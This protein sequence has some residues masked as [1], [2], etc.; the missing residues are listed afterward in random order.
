MSRICVL[1]CTF[2]R[3]EMLARLLAA[4]LP[5]AT[6]CGATV[7]IADN[8]TVSAQAVV[9]RFRGQMD[10]IYT[11]LPEPG[12]VNARNTTLRLALPLHPDYLVFIDDDE[13]PEG[14]WLDTLVQTLE[15]SGGDFATGPVLPHFS[16]PPPAWV[17]GS[18]FFDVDADCLGTSNLAIRTASLPGDEREW[19][20]PLFN[21][22]GGE[23]PELLRR[24]LAKGALHVIAEG[25][26]VHENVP[27]ER[28]RRRYIWRRG[29]R[30]GVVTAMILRLR[31]PVRMSFLLHLSGAMLGKTG[32]ALNHMF[33]SW[34]EPWRVIAAIADLA[35]VAGLVAAALG[36]RP[37]FYG[38][39]SKTR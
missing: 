22:T 21:F 35:A 13:L 9:D 16:E 3:H 37:T 5:Q 7:V 27:P 25:A 33:W 29:L 28:L 30:D 17:A 2:D 19:F 31:H 6:A 26:V 39:K 36:L 1:I 38:W 12:L 10:I 23:D 11:R 24:M 32:Y 4:L 18:R 8:G 14:D 20:N 15:S 34:A